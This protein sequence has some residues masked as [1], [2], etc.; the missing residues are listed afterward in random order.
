[1]Q[2]A[3]FCKDDKEQYYS[4][5]YSNRDPLGLTMALDESKELWH[6]IYSNRRRND[7]V[8][9]HRSREEHQV[10]QHV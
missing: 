9:N 2:T 4:D 6:D 1:M 8:D 7:E 5:H 3:P 10:K